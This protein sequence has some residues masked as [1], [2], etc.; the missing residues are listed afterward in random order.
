[1]PVDINTYRLRIGMFNR[2]SIFCSRIVCNLTFYFILLILFY[3]TLLLLI[4][5]DVHPNPGPRLGKLFSICHAN[6][7]SL[8]QDDKFRDIKTRLCE[9]FHVVTLSETFLSTKILDHSL[10]IDNFNLF[11]KDRDGWGGGVAAYVNSDIITVRRSEIEIHDIETM[12]LELQLLN[13]KIIVCVAYRPPNSSVEFWNKL[14][15]ELEY[16]RN[17]GGNTHTIIIGD[18]NAHTV[19]PAGKKL[20]EFCSANHLF[21]HNYSPTRI[22]PESATVLDQILT[23]ERSLE[24]VDILAPV[25]T[26]DHSV[27]GAKINL[28]TPHIL[29]SFKR[30]IWN[31]NNVDWENFR[32]NLQNTNWDECFL[33]E[34]VDEAWKLWSHKFN[35]IMSQCIVN[36][37]VTIRPRDKPWYNSLLRREN[38]KLEYHHKKAKNGNTHVLWESY[39]RARNL[40]YR[41]CRQA[42]SDYK[43]KIMSSLYD[44]VNAGSSKWWTL[45]KSFLGR[46]NNKGIG[47]IENNQTIIYD[48]SAKAEA[49][50]DFFVSHSNLDHLASNTTLP[51]DL[52]VN[53]NTLN[54]ITVTYQD[55]I[56]VLL[57]LKTSKA[58]GPDGIGPRVL[59]EAGVAIAAP[60]AKLINLS[61]KTNKVPTSWKR[62]NVIPI[63]KKNDP[64]SLNNYRPVSLLNCVA[65]VAEKVVFKYLYNFLHDNH[66]ISINQSGFKPGDSTENQL[67]DIYHTICQ[68]LDN[69]KDVRAI[70]CD[71][72]KAFDKVWHSGLIYKMKQAGVSEPL[73]G[74]FKNYLSD[75][76]QRVVLNNK[77]SPFKHIKAGVP[78]GSVLGPLLFLIY[79]N[80]I[81]SVISSPVRL[82]ADDT[83]IFLPVDSNNVQQA[84]RQLNDDL[85]SIQNWAKQWLVSFSPSKTKTITFSLKKT[86]KLDHPVLYFNNKAIEKVEFHKHL[87]LTLASNLTWGLHIDNISKKARRLVNL[88]SSLKHSLDRKS[89]ETMYISFVRPTLEYANQVWI[90]CTNEQSNTLDSIQLDS[91]RIVTG[92]IRGTGHDSMLNDLGWLSLSQRRQ[93]R[94]LYFFQKNFITKE[95]KYLYDHIPTF[96][97]S[98]S[99]YPLRNKFNLRENFSRTTIFKKSFFNSAISAWNKLDVKIRNIVDLKQFKKEI[100]NNTQVSSTKKWYY[101]GNRFYNKIHAKFRMQCSS[102]AAHLYNMHIIDDSSCSCGY[103]CEDCFHYFMQCPLYT[104]SRVVLMNSINTIS[105]FHLNILIF[106]DD[107]LNMESNI[108]MVEAVH[109]FVRGT[110]RFDP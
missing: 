53:L 18:L 45:L 27:L 23:N 46:T 77:M 61:L 54:N 80:D 48:D 87:G 106:G 36:K 73:L 108:R 20:S 13:T 58:A 94:Q 93:N 82:F 38:R 65:K 22:R 109:T 100:N 67:L 62:A 6:V 78:Q 15:I 55:V 107:S 96:V 91:A 86:K 17:I 105:S 5:G 30:K 71:I 74:W 32:T 49:F 70:F 43:A 33:N 76:Q 60:L 103:Q 11:R 85:N 4:A 47:P 31:Y 26:S 56:D 89:L 19:S 52:Q 44:P 104:R 8:M 83:S 3:L 95:P 39:K 79:I 75:R 57:N 101:H 25:Y 63:H 21:I 68:H 35:S 16:S 66:F 9:S 72:S 50:N 97:N 1:M 37:E 29:K 59:K 2:Y 12:W 51:P 69:G 10:Q 64:K 41:N 99:R 14:S 24:S 34:N 84:G 81:N 102:L 40:Y 98:V 88:M 92:A 110:G 90:N 28:A 7:R 42:E